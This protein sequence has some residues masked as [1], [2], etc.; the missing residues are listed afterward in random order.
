MKRPPTKRLFVGRDARDAHRLHTPRRRL[1]L[2]LTFRLVRLWAGFA[3]IC[4]RWLLIQ[5][6]SSDDPHES[7][8]YHQ[9]QRLANQLPAR[10][11][12]SEGQLFA[13]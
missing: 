5:G 1:Q 7:I 3:V 2:F 12:K 6:E 13:I 4:G 9:A 10:P 11:I 8:A